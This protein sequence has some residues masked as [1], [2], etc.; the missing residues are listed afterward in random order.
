[1]ISVYN[2]NST[3][4]YHMVQA[5]ER[6]A[7]QLEE[8]ETRYANLPVAVALK[9]ESDFDALATNPEAAA[10]FDAHVQEQVS[11]ALG[12][13]KTAGKKFSDLKFS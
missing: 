12:I 5:Q 2:L 1:M 7:K 6:F 9:Y 11:S 13:P 8:S 3:S 10:K 4:I